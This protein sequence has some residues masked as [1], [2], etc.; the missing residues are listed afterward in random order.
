M[1][2][3]PIRA[4][5]LEPFPRF[6]DPGEEILIDP[7][8]V[9]KPVRGVPLDATFEVRPLYEFEIHL[10]IKNRPHWLPLVRKEFLQPLL[11]LRLV[12]VFDHLKG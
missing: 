9:C 10:W 2:K 4:H 5:P 3:M 11:P 6:I 8:R 7:D 12:L 1:H